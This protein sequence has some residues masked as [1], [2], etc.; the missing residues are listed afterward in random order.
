MRLLRL[1]LVN[2]RSHADLDLRLD[3]VSSAAILG[4]NGAGKTS[5]LAAVEWGLYGSGGAETFLRDGAQ[6]MSVMLEVEQGGTR[7]RVA[8]GRERKRGGW[9]TLDRLD[10]DGDRSYSSRTVAETQAR[11]VEHVTGLDADAFRATVYAPQGEAGLLAALPPARRKELL[12]G[13]LGLERYDEWRQAAA[14]EARDASSNAHALAVE[15]ERL[16]GQL[17]A[18]E[19]AAGDAQARDDAVDAA[20]SAVAQAEA[21]VDAA[22]A[23]ERAREG[24]RL[25][26]SLVAQMAALRERGKRSR[27]TAKR[28]AALQAQI[29]QG[30]GV[31][32]RF[33]AAESARADFER[34]QAEAR[35]QHAAAERERLRL[36]RDH[37]AAEQE[38]ARL[39]RG[40]QSR[41]PS[42]TVT[43][44]SSPRWTAASRTARPA[45]R[46]S[47]TRPWTPPARPSP[48]AGR[49]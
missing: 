5:L 17:H 30:E 38:A 12:S 1:K 7:W 28:R 46:R 14:L 32:A 36:R 25:R 19:E 6:R 40:E 33:D 13:L 18:A 2:F 24:V 3:G 31:R 27:K 4:P 47:P 48:A 8:R 43:A 44:R 21:A 29:D 20:S 41:P 45:S 26:A 39:R 15:R 34:R 9:L 11:V 37:A 23:A 10:A 42:W 35:A 49:T 16:I 22:L